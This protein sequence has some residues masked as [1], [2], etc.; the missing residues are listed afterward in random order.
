MNGPFSNSDLPIVD[1]RIYHL[2]LAPDELAPDIILVGDPGRADEIAE[3]HFETVEVRR[4]HR[5]LVTVTGTA[6]TNG[7][8]LSVVTSGMGTPSLEIVL[9]EIYALSSIDF[10]TKQRKSS[11]KQLHVIR[12]GTSGA[13]QERTPLGALIVTDYAIGLDNTGLFYEV[14]PPDFKSVELERRA[15]AAIETAVRKES[16]FSGVIRPYVSR[17]D[18]VL[19]EKLLARAQQSEIPVRKGVTVSN[20]GFFANQGRHISSVVPTVPDIDAVFAELDTG[21]PDLKVENMEMEASFLLHFLAGIGARGG[22]ICVGIANRRQD[23]FASGW[24]DS[25]H[26]ATEVA[27]ETLAELRR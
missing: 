16:R 4:E 10:Q 19:T 14:S 3:N 8:R 15:T 18:V 22:A 27:I 5:G 17:A 6:R 20:S 2:T 26:V 9:N 25:V 13:L 1:G 12:L 7:H 24:R 11:P 21:I 23:T